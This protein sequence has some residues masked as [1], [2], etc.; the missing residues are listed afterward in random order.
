MWE[1]AWIDAVLTRTLNRLE[2]QRVNKY[3]L[4]SFVLSEG[5]KAEKGNPASTKV[6][7]SFTIDLD[8][9]STHHD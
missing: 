8:G 6:R 2:D 9:H 1:L 3:T 5:L 7:G 4:P